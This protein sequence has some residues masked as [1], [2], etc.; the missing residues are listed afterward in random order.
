MGAASARR[1]RPVKMVRHTL[2]LRCAGCG[3][4]HYF[5]VAADIAAG[6][7]A[8]DAEMKAT[9]AEFGA[10]CP[11]CEGRRVLLFCYFPVLR[12]TGLIGA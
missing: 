3:E 10:P 11:H 1:L 8:L 6:A 2:R 12:H 4:F 7:Q 9:A 5:D